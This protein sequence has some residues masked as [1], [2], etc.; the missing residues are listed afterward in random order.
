MVT[1]HDRLDASTA[2]RT[3]LARD[4]HGYLKSP[5]SVLEEVSG[6]VENPILASDVQCTPSRAPLRRRCAL[7]RQ[8]D[9]VAACIGVLVV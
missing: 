4:P 8:N 6:T 2:R 7:T 3:S 9:Q 1:G 5:S